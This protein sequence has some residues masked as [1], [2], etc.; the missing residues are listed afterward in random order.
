[1]VVG[2]QRQR[3]IDAGGDPGRGPHRAVALVDPV[4]VDG[5]ARVG[6]QRVGRQPV[7]GGPA[8]GEQSGLGEQQRPAAHRGG[9]PRQRRQPGDLRGQAEMPLHGQAADDHQR[10]EVA[11]DLGQGH[12]RLDP[13][14]G[15]RRDRA[16]GRRRDLGPVPA[17]RRGEQRR[18]GEDVGG[19]G[20]VE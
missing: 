20:E 2:D 9:P 3:Q 10:V 6:G 1:V 12:R 18:R 17:A 7:R 13:G 5:D 4:G 19:P 8:T 16:G 11:G 14:P 15:A